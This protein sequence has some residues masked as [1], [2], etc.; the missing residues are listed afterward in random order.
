MIFDFLPL[1]IELGVLAGLTV[2]VSG[3]LQAYAKVDKD[4]KREKF[5]IDKFTITVLLGLVAGGLLGSIN[6]VDSGIAIFLAS[7]G[8]V[9]IIDSLVKTFLRSV[10]K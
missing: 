2:A 9:A 3:Y 10:Q 5:S 8:I 1:E 6:M 4:G 7:A